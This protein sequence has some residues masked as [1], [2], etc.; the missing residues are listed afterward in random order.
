MK[1]D[2]ITHKLK[3]ISRLTLP[4]CRGWQDALGKHRKP[5]HGEREALEARAKKLGASK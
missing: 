5:F 4:E 1:P 3:L 2:E